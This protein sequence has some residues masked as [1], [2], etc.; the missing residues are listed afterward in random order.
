MSTAFMAAQSKGVKGVNTF[1]DHFALLA[2]SCPTGH[3]YS[4]TGG[5]NTQH[6][7]FGQSGVAGGNGNVHFGGPATLIVS[8]GRKSCFCLVTR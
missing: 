1:S 4:P 2:C 6:K 3:S 7:H 5:L 8:K